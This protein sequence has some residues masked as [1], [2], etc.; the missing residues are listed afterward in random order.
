M[1]KRPEFVILVLLVALAAVAWRS[2]LAR[3]ALLE[4]HVLD[5][6]QGDAILI[7]LPDT[8]QILID[9]GPDGSVLTELSA[10]MGPLDKTLDVVIATHPDKDHIGGLPDVLAAYDVGTIVLTGAEK[11]TNLYRAWVAAVA[12]EGAQIVLADG[13]KRLAFG[14]LAVLDLLWPQES[15]LGKSPSSVN[16]YAVVSRLTYGS[17][18]FLFTG[19]I[20]MWTEQRLVR[21]GILGDVEVLKIPHHGSKTS[22]TT[23]LLRVTTPKIAVISVGKENRYGHPS[24]L[25]LTRLLDFGIETRRTDLE[26]RIT[27]QSDGEAFWVVD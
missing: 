10:V 21:S 11:D 5:V 24:D 20:E 8:T 1:R 17:V 23:A 6:G 15:M 13:I 25:V 12:S 19:D 18:D 14:D 22:T 9:G 26:G 3:T 7:E 4:V 27:I 16:D 2:T